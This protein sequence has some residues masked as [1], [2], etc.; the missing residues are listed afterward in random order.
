MYVCCLWNIVIGKK[1][2]N[3]FLDQKRQNGLNRKGFPQKNEDD[4]RQTVEYFA[5]A[6]LI[7]GKTYK[8]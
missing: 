3:F 5:P 6:F 4:K 7:F 8:F 2:G 1:I